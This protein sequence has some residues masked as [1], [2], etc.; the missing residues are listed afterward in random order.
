M[1][2]G[3]VLGP[4][5]AIISIEHALT[6]ANDTRSRAQEALLR[7]LDEAYAGWETD[8]R[9][10]EAARALSEGFTRR[11]DERTPDLELRTFRAA[12]LAY[13]APRAIAATDFTLRS[14]FALAP[15]SI[16]LDVG[17]GTGGAALVA[18]AA[19]ARRV[20][21][22][23][24]DPQA[25]SVAERL[26]GALDKTPLMETRAIEF[27]GSAWKAPF[28]TVLLSAFSLGELLR[29]HS[30]DE[31]LDKLMD[32]AP[33]ATRWLLIDAGDS[34]RARKM[35]SFREA[36]LSRAFRITAPC[37]HASAC[38]ALVR[39]RDWCHTKINRA[40]PERLAAFARAV[41]RDDTFMNLSYLA[42]DRVVGHD[43]PQP[44]A[45]RVLG[46][47]IR[48]KGRLRLPVCGPDG[49]RFLQALK[50]H[51]GA[52][53]TLLEMARGQEFGLTGT[54]RKG[55]TV[56]V[57][58]AESISPHGDGVGPTPDIR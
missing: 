56:H 26:L 34:A 27:F 7:H 51:R 30:E 53:R 13:F 22:L 32:A 21:L 57:D 52:H 58:N 4:P 35:Q 20:V 41:G 9:I 43:V 37:P 6:P 50:R 40:L 19:G 15:D 10:L 36:A 28:A 25:L 14:S 44:S 42:L 45:L 48:E 17:S 8:S 16:V 5:A 49:I 39:K 2:A 1:L 3:K 46:D 47:P 33:N 29:E 38:P 18:A 55:D 11:P 12:Y 23:D 54:T 31:V 24:R